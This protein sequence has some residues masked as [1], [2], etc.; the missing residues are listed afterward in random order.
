MGESQT[1]ATVQ[2]GPMMNTGVTARPDTAV[3]YRTILRVN[4][5]LIQI[6]RPFYIVQYLILIQLYSKQNLGTVMI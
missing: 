2:Y 1:F 3:H 4:H 5:T 6:V